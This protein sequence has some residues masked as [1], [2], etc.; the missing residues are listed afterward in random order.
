MKRYILTREKMAKITEPAESISRPTGPKRRNPASPAR[1]CMSVSTTDY[2]SNRK[3][4]HIVYFWMVQFEVYQQQRG[5]ESKHA[6]EDSENERWNNAC[7]AVVNRGPCCIPKMT[8]TRV[9]YIPTTAIALGRV[10]IPL[11]M[12]SAIIIALASLRK[13]DE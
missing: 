10:S 2:G 1:H 13:N 3:R 12:I 6:Q 11:L 9:V 4:T 5:I 8:M 7:V